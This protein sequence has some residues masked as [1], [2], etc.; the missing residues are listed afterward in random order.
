MCE[1]QYVLSHWFTQQELYTVCETHLTVLLL[2]QASCQSLS[3]YLSSTF[4]PYIANVT[5]AAILCSQ[6]LCQSKG[7]CV[8]K[9]SDSNYYLH[10]NSAHFSIL[11][12]DRKYVA[13]GLP[14]SADLDTWAENFTCQCY[15][16]WS[17]Y[18]KLVYPKTIKVIWV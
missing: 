13:T 14:S 15:V 11:K 9:I 5:A 6:V 1:L 7:R 18:P 10:L 16:G 17:C 3:E 2:L 8:R 4:S 12:S